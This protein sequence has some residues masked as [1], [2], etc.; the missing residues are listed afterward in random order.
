MS[1][2]VHIL[3]T[4]TLP[5]K[6]TQLSKYE[7]NIVLTQGFNRQIR[8]MCEAHGYNVYQLKRIRIMNIHLDKLP[9]GQWRYLSKKEKTRLFSDLNYEPKEW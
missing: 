6:V 4:K 9:I 2:G 8:R 5:C 1:D 3:G 7:F